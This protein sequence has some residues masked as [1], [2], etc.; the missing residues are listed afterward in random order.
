M[1]DT[2][3]R[4]DPAEAAFREVFVAHA[5]YVWRCLRRLGVSPADVED[6]CQEVFVV[7]H[8]KLRDLQPD[9]P[10]RAWLYGIAVRKAWDHRRLAYQR[11]E[12]PTDELPER[13]EE[14]AQGDA[15]DR[16][17]ARDLLDQLLDKLDPKQREVFVLYEIEQLGMNEIAA[18]LDCPLQTAYSRLHAAR[19]QMQAAADRE[20]ARRASRT[21]APSGGRA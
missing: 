18:A 20:R 16:R 9:A 7:V 6:L 5:P 2:L 19:K 3:E 8:R 10:L 17:T 11:H 12:R 15:L 21:G 1:P 13:S 14:A 4:S